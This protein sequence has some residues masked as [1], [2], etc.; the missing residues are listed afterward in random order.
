MNK[1]ELARRAGLRHNE[2][3]KP[4]LMQLLESFLSL[5]RDA[6]PKAQ[7]SPPAHHNNSSMFEG[8]PS[9]NASQSVNQPAKRLDDRFGDDSS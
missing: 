2:G 4:I 6:A 1:D 3:N 7:Q 9:Q 5:D 8:A